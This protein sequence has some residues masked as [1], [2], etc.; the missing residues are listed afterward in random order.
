MEVT[1][2]FKNVILLQSNFLNFTFQEQSNSLWIKRIIC[3][4]NKYGEVFVNTV[5]TVFTLSSE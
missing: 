1:D 4:Q 3:T 5:F 2:E